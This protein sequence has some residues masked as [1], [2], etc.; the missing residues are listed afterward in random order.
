[1][2]LQ[3]EVPQSILCPT[4]SN[5]EEEFKNSGMG[6]FTWLVFLVVWL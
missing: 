6:L 4:F 5:S 1:M 2:Q 3:G